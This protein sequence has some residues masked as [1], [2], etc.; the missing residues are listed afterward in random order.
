[1]KRHSYLALMAFL[2]PLLVSS[3]PD[4]Q[5]F[6]QQGIITTYAGGGPNSS[7][8][9]SADIDPQSVAVDEGKPVHC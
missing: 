8:A 3:G 1:M 7:V 2:P 9:L 4:S 6:V 5:A